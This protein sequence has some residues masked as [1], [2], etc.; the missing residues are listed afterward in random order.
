MKGRSEVRDKINKTVT[1][2][3]ES[4]AALKTFAS[5]MTRFTEVLSCREVLPWTRSNVSLCWV[6]V[7]NNVAGKHRIDRL[8]NLG[9]RR[10]SANAFNYPG[11]PIK[12]LKDVI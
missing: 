3:T 11:P 6:P 7:H 10:D 5:R 1:I 2:Q 9:S 4:H 12:S 8:E